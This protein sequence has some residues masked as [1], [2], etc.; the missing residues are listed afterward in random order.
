MS[1]QMPSSGT[2]SYTLCAEQAR[3]IMSGYMSGGAVGR[4]EPASSSR[5]A[6]VGVLT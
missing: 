4:A 6:A 3:H 2:R 5:R 1:S